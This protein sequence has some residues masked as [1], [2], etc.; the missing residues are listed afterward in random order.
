MLKYTDIIDDK[1]S[2]L[3]LV[4][5]FRRM[6]MLYSELSSGN[7]AV[8]LAVWMSERFCESLASLWLFIDWCDACV[9][10][11]RANQIR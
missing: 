9:E 5:V 2:I 7:K 10:V 11:S 8:G 3:L 4:Y 1:N 6:T